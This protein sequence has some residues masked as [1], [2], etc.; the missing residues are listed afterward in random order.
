MLSYWNWFTYYNNRFINGLRFGIKF[1]DFYDFYDLM[2]F[3]SEIYFGSYRPNTT[4]ILY[5][6]LYN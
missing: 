6:Y 4:N 2:Y 1:M 5:Y 3:L